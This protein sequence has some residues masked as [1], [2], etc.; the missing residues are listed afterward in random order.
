MAGTAIV[1]FRNDLRLADNPA[2]HHARS[3]HDRVVP[4]FIEDSA[5]E[6]EWARGAAS[7][8]WLHHSL[9]ALDQRLRQR[10]V[11]LVVARGDAEA[12]LIRI[13]NASGACAVYWNRRYE[14][15][16]VARD[17]QLKKR[18]QE[19]GLTVHSHAA[20]L[21][22]EPW[23]LRKDDDT[24]YRVF[25]PYWRRMQREWRLP[26]PHPEP[27]RL[28]GPSRWPASLDIDA[29]GLLPAIDWTDGLRQAWNPGEPGAR[30]SLE[31]FLGLA[32]ADYHHCR[33]R[34]DRAGTS[35]LSPHLRFGEISS[36]QVARALQPSGELPDGKGRLVFLSEIAWREFSYHLLWHF[37]D[38]PERAL[39][40]RFRSFPWRRADDYRGDL[41]A[42]QAGMTGVPMVDAGMRELWATGW[43]HNRLRM[44]VASFLTKNLLIPWQEGAR[45]FWDTLVDADLANN[46]QGWQ[47]TAGCGVDAAPY[48]RVFNPVLQGQRFD[49]DGDYVR[50]WC[51]ELKERGSERIHRPLSARESSQLGYPTACVDLA[52]SRKRALAAWQGIC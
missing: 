38:M 29:L 19:R 7:R 28:N 23:C 51:P 36:A 35:R 11:R 9:T 13:R 41:E 37:P 43:M 8:W 24:P 42:W 5:A 31:R 25:T 1:W 45:W 3:A 46:S 50:C 27:R 6:P 10:G 18:L 33:D 44:I 22:F 20:S 2:L 15:P 47:W 16:G 34:P 21:L 40:H 32:V 52:A 4:V 12:E 14:A 48:F 49:P 17:R 39:D 30:R 26:D